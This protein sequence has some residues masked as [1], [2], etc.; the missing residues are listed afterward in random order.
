MMKLRRVRSTPLATELAAG[1]ARMYPSAQGKAFHG[2]QRLSGNA[3]LAAAAMLRVLTNF[4]QCSA[5]AQ[6]L[7]R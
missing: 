7:A 3:L 1:Q 6:A 4:G 2:S 5:G